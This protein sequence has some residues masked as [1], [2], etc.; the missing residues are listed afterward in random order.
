MDTKSKID[1]IKSVIN[2]W[3]ST[4]ASQLELE[5]SPCLF[6]SGSGKNSTIVLVESFYSAAVFAVTYNDDI[7]ISESWIPYEELDKEAIDEIY[8]IIIAYEKSN[9][10]TYGSNE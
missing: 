10:I 8:S 4:S 6:S 7:L 3:G 2:E 1:Y 5:S 9:I